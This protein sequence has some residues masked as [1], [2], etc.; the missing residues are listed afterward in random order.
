[1]HRWGQRFAGGR[2][3]S[4][5]VACYRAGGLYRRR[6]GDISDCAGVHGGGTGYGRGRGRVRAAVAGREG[7]VVP[8][9][10]K[11]LC[12]TVATQPA[13]PAR[14]SVTVTFPRGGRAGWCRGRRFP[15]R[16][17]LV[18]AAMVRVP[19]GTVAA[20][21][22]SAAEA[23]RARAPSRAAVAVKA[24]V[25]RVELRMRCPWTRSQLPSQYQSR[26][27]SLTG[28]RPAAVN[29]WGFKCLAPPNEP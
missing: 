8:V 5:V 17:L 15:A 22:V 19:V 2:V 4:G 12:S 1:M 3:P 6:G 28:I 10:V 29:L 16:R 7:G 27:C 11:L 20:R 9:P 14:S 23:G 21:G 24:S 26:A 18:G 25:R 13:V